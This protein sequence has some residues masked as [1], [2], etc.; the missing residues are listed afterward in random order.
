MRVRW[1]LRQRRCL[2]F[3]YAIEG[4]E[5]TCTSGFYSLAMREVV[6]AAESCVIALSWLSRTAR[7]VGAAR[8]G[9]LAK[10]DWVADFFAYTSG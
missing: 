1:L 10:N 2:P 3:G 5:A 6:G 8:F 7:C 4:G 9:L